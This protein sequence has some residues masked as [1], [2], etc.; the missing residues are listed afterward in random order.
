MSDVANHVAA[1]ESDL[2]AG[3]PLGMDGRYS[4]AAMAALQPFTQ[5]LEPIGGTLLQS[6]DDPGTDIGPLMLAGVPAFGLIQ[7]NRTYFHYHHTAADTLDKIN[8]RE[9]SENAALLAV[10]AFGIAD[11]PHT[12]P[13]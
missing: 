7:D 11:A 4:A 12:L 13:R 2:G 3:H 8:P 6:N 5:I 9:L 10:Y 1:F